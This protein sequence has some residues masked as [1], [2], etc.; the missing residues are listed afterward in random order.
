MKS[1]TDRPD[2]HERPENPK[3]CM[4]K[5]IVNPSVEPS[6]TL[7]FEKGNL[8]IKVVTPNPAYLSELANE[9]NSSL[10]GNWNY[11]VQ[12]NF[13]S[14]PE[15]IKTNTHFKNTI[16][17]LFGCREFIEFRDIKSKIQI[18]PAFIP[19]KS[20]M[21]DEDCQNCALIIHKYVNQYGA[22][23]D[24]S[25]RTPKGIKKIHSYVKSVV[26]RPHL[27]EEDALRIADKLIEKH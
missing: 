17:K 27:T 23:P 14:V 15:T 25:M 9:M 12:F 11:K 10:Q 24:L 8:D 18:A 6:Y 4:V 20:K 21:S 1:N 19:N 5:I 2:H 3:I 13:K 26:A 16:Y 7:K 22:S